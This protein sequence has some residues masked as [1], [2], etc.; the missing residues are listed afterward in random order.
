MIDPA[1]LV[2]LNLADEYEALCGFVVAAREERG[3]ELLRGSRGVV[4]GLPARR[5]S[6]YRAGPRE[7]H[8]VCGKPPPAAE[9]WCGS[10]GG[11]FPVPT[12]NLL[13]SQFFETD[14]AEDIHGD[15]MRS[16]WKELE[17]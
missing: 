2:R 10:L 12:P 13:Q 17:A 4:V 11:I 1:T 6:F 15:S 8:H 14:G 3:S 7:I 5:R 16:Y 9:T